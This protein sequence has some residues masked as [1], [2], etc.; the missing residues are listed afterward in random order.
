MTESST[1]DTSATPRDGTH[2]FDFLHGSWTI[3]NRRLRNPLS[4]SSDWYDFDGATVER[5]LWNGQANLEEWEGTLPDGSR[6][7][8]LALRLYDR[9]SHQWSIYWSNAAT[10][11]LDSPMIGEFHNGLGIFY[12]HEGY[13]GRMIF[14]RFHWSTSS[15]EH[16]RWEQAFS[17]DGG[18]T[19]ETNW[20]MDFT[21]VSDVAPRDS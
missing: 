13:Q 18:A 9:K 19:W 21:R 5:S 4:G 16:A 14:V 2:D 17:A 8:G 15:R 3:R 7:R 12:G 11:T 20:I 10:G 1:H 6:L